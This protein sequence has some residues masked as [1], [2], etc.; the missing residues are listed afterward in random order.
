MTEGR[1]QIA[2]DECNER[3]KRDARAIRWVID[4]LTED[5]ELEPFVLGIPGSLSSTWG[6]KVWEIV[7]EGEEGGNILHLP[8]MNPSWHSYF[9]TLVIPLFNP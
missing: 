1:V 7:A 2:M 6:K 5:S 8:S 4:N 9:R 3:K